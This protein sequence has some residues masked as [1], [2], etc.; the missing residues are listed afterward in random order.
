M[1]GGLLGDAV[2]DVGI[3][4]TGQSPQAVVC[5]LD[6]EDARQS[7]QCRD[8]RW[9]PQADGYVRD[10]LRIVGDGRVMYQSALMDDGHAPATGL[11]LRQNVTG[12]D[13]TVVFAQPPDQRA[14]LADLIGI[15]P[16]GGFVQNHHI[17]AVQ[18]RLRNPRAL[19]VAA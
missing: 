13:H 2:T 7:G 8:V 17:G 15:Q 19:L 12:D 9:M 3:C 14:N 1:H 6:F 11:D 18:N 10:L 16:D 5:C 4:L